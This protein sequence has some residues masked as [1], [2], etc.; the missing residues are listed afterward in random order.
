MLV[1]ASSSFW[2]VNWTKFCPWA[3]ALT[4]FFVE[5]HGGW[6]ESFQIK[7][8]VIRMRSTCFICWIVF[9]FRK[10]SYRRCPEKY[11]F[12][13]GVQWKFFNQI[14]LMYTSF[15]LV[16]NILPYWLILWQNRKFYFWQYELFGWGTNKMTRLNARQPTTIVLDNSTISH[17]T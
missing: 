11:T 16:Y 8:F 3:Q 1:S 2:L 6:R 12:P 15:T 14:I 10:Y 5:N 4:K 13:T 9:L 7:Y 17:P